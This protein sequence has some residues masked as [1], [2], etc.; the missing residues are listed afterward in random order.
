MPMKM[1]AQS[2]GEEER[3]SLASGKG[4]AGADPVLGPSSAFDLILFQN[5][6]KVKQSEDKHR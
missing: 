3:P 2:L 6:G 5:I 4:K 1:T